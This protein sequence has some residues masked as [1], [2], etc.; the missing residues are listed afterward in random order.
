MAAGAGQLLGGIVMG[1]TADWTGRRLGYGV[2]VALSSVATAAASLAPSLGW[3]DVLMFLAGLGFGGVAPV[4]TSLVGEFAPRQ[5]RGALMGWT[6]VIWILGWLVAAAGGVVLLREFGW[7]GVFAI[8]ILPVALAVLGPRL[9]P[10]SPRFLLAHGRRDEA[11]ALAAALRERFGSGG[12]LP[13]QERAGRVSVAAHLRELWSARFR[14]RTVLLWTV[15]F[16]MIAAYQGPVVWLPAMMAAAG[17][18]NAAGVSFVVVAAALPVTVA[19]TLLLDRVG[20]KPVMITALSLAAAGA[21]AVAGARDTLT[22]VLGGVGLAGGVLAAWPVI[23]SYAAELYPTRIR[24]TA[25]G[26]ASA[27][28]RAASILA[29][30]L[31]G[32]LMSTW[33]QG[34]GPAMLVFA[35][36]LAAAAVIVLVAGEETAG[37]SLEEITDVAAPGVAASP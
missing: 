19:S 17:I 22:F 12:E 29:P 23:L 3:L 36:L 20:R 14:R 8:G 28:G 18:P 21:A 7:R 34:R 25:I 10:E 30:A 13:D 1:Y 24:A 37:R 27:A 4:A 11:E 15:W 35:A 16:A 2:T 33:S 26:W 6:Q 5:Q 9:V 32:I 31:L